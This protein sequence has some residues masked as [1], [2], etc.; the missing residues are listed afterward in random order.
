[1]GDV[2]LGD[3]DDVLAH[4][5]LDLSMEANRSASF[6]AG[7]RVLAEL[8][9]V[10]SLHKR[11]VE[12]A[13]FVVL[14]APDVPSILVETGYISNPQEARLLSTAAHQE[15]IASAIAAGVRIHMQGHAPPGTLL[16]WQRLQP[17]ARYTISRGDTLS[18]IAARY[19]TSTRR[20]REANG[21]Q[22]DVIQV[23]QTIVI[24]AG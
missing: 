21:L 15:R 8:G 16:A 24:P 6:R 11:R 7:E 4:V 3:K 5:L 22:S 17:N 10:A 12:Q 14:K 20:L 1:V 18:E 2:T 19:G 13:G 23:G 9:G